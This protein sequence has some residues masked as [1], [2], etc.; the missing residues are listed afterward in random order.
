MAT[1]YMPCNTKRKDHIIILYYKNTLKKI[2][3]DGQKTYL[4]KETSILFITYKTSYKNTESICTKTE[5]QLKQTYKRSLKRTSNIYRQK[6]RLNTN[7][8]L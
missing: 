6:R 4:P 2:S 1:Y 7:L 3:K 8:I 5:H